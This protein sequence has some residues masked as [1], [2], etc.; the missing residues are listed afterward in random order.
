[1]P[2]LC[3]M[4]A[5]VFLWVGWLPVLAGLGYFSNVLLAAEADFPPALWHLWSL[6]Q[7]EQFYIVWPLLLLLVSP[8]LIMLAITLST[9]YLGVLLA[10]SD[11]QRA[12]FD[13][14]AHAAPIL[15]GCLLAIVGV[16][17]SRIAYAAPLLLL[18]LLLAP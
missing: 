12:Y 9:I 7:E 15:A 14:L 6:A 8:R 13:P 1:M 10:T 16:R 3:V 11:W 4:L 2:A 18:L 5:V 17:S